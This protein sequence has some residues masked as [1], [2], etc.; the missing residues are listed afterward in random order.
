MAIRDTGSPTLLALLVGNLVMHVGGP[1]IDTTESFPKTG[2]Y[3]AGQVIHLVLGLAIIY[4]M[5]ARKPGRYARS[6]G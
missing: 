1:L 3:W 4:Y 6:Q 2:G 5:I